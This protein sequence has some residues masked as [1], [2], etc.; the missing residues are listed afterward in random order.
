MNTKQV[1]TKVWKCFELILSD[2]YRPRPLGEH[3]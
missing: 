3:L 1:S 2:F